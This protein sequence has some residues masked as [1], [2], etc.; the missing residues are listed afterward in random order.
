MKRTIAALLGLLVLAAP[1]AAQIPERLDGALR[2]IYGQGQYSAESFGPVVWLDNGTRYATIGGAGLTAY[3]TA[4]GTATTLATPD[5]LNPAGTVDGFSVSADASKVLLFTNTRRVWRLN[6]RGDYWVLDL[7]THKLQQIGRGAPASTLMFAKFSPDGTRVAFVRQQ[8]IYV[9]DLSAGRVTALTNGRE[10]NIINGTSDWVNEEELFIRDAFTWSPDGRQIAYLQFDTSRVGRFTLINYTDALYPT[11]TEFAYPKTGTTNSAVRLGIVRA[12]G[13]QTRWLTIPGD[14]REHYIPRFEWV[15]ATTLAFH[16][17]ARRQNADELLLADSRTGTITTAH[18]EASKTWLDAV[19]P[20]VM[21]PVRTAWW[22]RGAG[23]FTWISDRDGWRHVYAISRQTR[24]ETL[25]TRFDGDAMNIAGVDRDRDV[26]YFV[27][28]PD[29]ATER[30]LYAARVNDGSVTRVT[31]PGTPGTHTYEMS[32]DGRWAFHTHSRADVPPRIDLIALPD[33]RLVRTLVTNDELAR[34]T[35]ALTRQPV[36]FTEVTIQD[37]VTLD[38]LVIKPTDFDA[39]HRYPMLVYVYGEPADTLVDDQWSTARLTF[40]AIADEG[41]VVVMFDNRGT[42][43]PKGAAWRKVVYG[44]IGDLGPREQAEAVKRFAATHAYVDPS[45]VA[46]YGHSGGGSST[47]HALFK[48]PEVYRV[49][50]ASAPVPDQRLYDTIYQERY[51]GL[52]QDNPE[53][54]RVGSSINFAEG[55][56]SRLLLMHGT[57]DDNVHLQNTERLMNRLIELGKDFDVMFYPNRT[58]ALSEGPGTALHRWRTIARYL[59]EHMPPTPQTLAP[60][61][62]SPVPSTSGAP[63]R[64]R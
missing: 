57:G 32:P 4:S 21:D 19:D 46:I 49:G 28:S 44:H 5:Q 48:Y 60:G 58:H 39:S 17:T 42:P 62:Q 3:D 59:L 41:Y 24:S 22:L 9:E 54:Y 38:T 64:T 27:A 55:L 15:D 33:H 50:I 7:R 10:T 56:R 16:Y 31:P 6:T 13:G 47:L 40:R 61:P 25:V 20:M 52:P 30:Y 51:M 11:L 14:Q 26:L 8:N 18:A 23:L 36:E 43:A 53:G 34:R 12:T 2:A 63:E 1:V 37:G 29:N 35:A 45:R